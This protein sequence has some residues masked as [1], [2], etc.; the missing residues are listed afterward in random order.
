[1]LYAYKDRLMNSTNMSGVTHWGGPR[2]VPSPLRQSEFIDEE[3]Q[4]G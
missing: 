4:G 2:D 3:G 1:M